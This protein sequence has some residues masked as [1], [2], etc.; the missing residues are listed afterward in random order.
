MMTS[1]S[2]YGHGHINFQFPRFDSRKNINIDL[3]N[4]MSKIN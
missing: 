2:Q 1:T 3:N 4:D